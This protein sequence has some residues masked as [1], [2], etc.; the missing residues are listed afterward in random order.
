M[1]K[2]VE[3]EEKESA[4]NNLFTRGCNEKC[5]CKRGKGSGTGGGAVYFFGLV[6]SLIYFFQHLGVANVGNIVMALIKSIIWP[7]LLVYKILELWKF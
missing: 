3:K 2:E 4:K 5:R 6:G 7:G 1:A